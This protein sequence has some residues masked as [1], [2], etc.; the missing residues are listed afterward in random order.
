M[1]PRILP[2]KLFGWQSFAASWPVSFLITLALAAPARSQEPPP[3]AQSIADAA[4]NTREQKSNSTKQPKIITNDDLQVQPPVPSVQ[5]PTPNP[6]ASPS[7]SFAATPAESTAKDQTVVAEVAEAPKPQAAGCDNPAAEKLK[8]DLQAALDD[9]DQIRRELSYNPGVISGP[10][11]DMTNFKPGSSGLDVG[12]P[13]LLQS[14]PQ[15][16]ARVMEVILDDKVASLKKA[17]TIACDSPENAG[18]QKKLDVAEQELHRLLGRF[19]LDQNSYYSTPNFAADTAGKAK[20]DAGQQQIQ[21]LQSEIERL[22]DELAASKA[23]Q[24]P[25]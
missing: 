24:N 20:L 12:S 19:G 4:R 11:L 15:A 23:N 16:P 13:A 7:E 8:A 10:N 2:S 22:K 5:S 9:Q 3:T 25:K 1:K 17:L 14:Q 6:S 21:D 18:I